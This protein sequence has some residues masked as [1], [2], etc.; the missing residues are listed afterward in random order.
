MN[1]DPYMRTIPLRQS[2]R[3]VPDEQCGTIRITDAEG[4]PPPSRMTRNK[5]DPPSSS[6][7]PIR[8][9]QPRPNS[10]TATAHGTQPHHAL[11][12]TPPEGTQ[13]LELKRSE[14]TRGMSARGRDALEYQHRKKSAPSKPSTETTQPNTTRAHSHT[15]TVT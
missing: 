12:D 13:P 9:S 10:P 8:E 6:P 1:L 14:R 15:T 11:Y 2:S 3:Y 7:A 5:G 4:T